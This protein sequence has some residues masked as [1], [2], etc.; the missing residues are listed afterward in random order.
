MG[1]IQVIQILPIVQNHAFSGQLEFLKCPFVRVNGV[2][3]FNGDTGP[4][5]PKDPTGYKE[6]NIKHHFYFCILSSKLQW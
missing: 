5:D 3:V 6:G 1:F 2:C 4:G